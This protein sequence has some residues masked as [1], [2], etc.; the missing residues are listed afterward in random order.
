MQFPQKFFFFGGGGG[1]KESKKKGQFQK[2]FFFLEG[3]VGNMREQNGNN[4]KILI[5][6]LAAITD[7]SLVLGTVKC[8]RK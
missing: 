8:C 6:S 4:T 5:N 1:E 3:G 2:I 7:A